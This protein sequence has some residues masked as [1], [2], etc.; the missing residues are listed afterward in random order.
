MGTTLP[1]R[2]QPTSGLCTLANVWMM[3]YRWIGKAVVIYGWAY[4]RRRYGRQLKLGVAAALVA[5]VGAVAAASYLAS[6]D[7]PEG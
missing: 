2:R 3:V 1:L 4:V 5:G 7:L 6:R